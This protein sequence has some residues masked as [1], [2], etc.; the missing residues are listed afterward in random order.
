MVKI[1]FKIDIIWVR[2]IFLNFCIMQKDYVAWYS[3]D[4]V[5]GGWCE[6]W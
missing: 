3:G 1:K 4:L 6:S 2:L 5:F